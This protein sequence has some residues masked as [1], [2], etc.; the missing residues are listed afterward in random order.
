MAIEI[1]VQSPVA[2]VK[3]EE[4]TDEAV[5]CAP[6]GQAPYL[7]LLRVTRD[8]FSDGATREIGREIVVIPLDQLMANP[9]AAELVG[10]L[11]PLFDALVQ[12]HRAAA[13]AQP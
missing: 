10:T 7:Q 13:A 2:F 5:I 8:T 1:P 4:R 11:P 12:A 3:R 6:L 9:Q